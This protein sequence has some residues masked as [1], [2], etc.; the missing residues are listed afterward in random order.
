MRRLS[1]LDSDLEAFGR[2]PAHGSSFPA[3][4]AKPVPLAVVSLDSRRD[5]GNLVN[6]FMRIGFPLSVP[7]RVDCS[8]PEEGPRKSRSKSVPDRHAVARSRRGSSSSDPP[9]AD[10]FGTRTPCPPSS[11]SFS[12]SY[13]SILPTS[14]AYILPSTGGCSPWRPDAVMSTTGRER[15]SVLRIFKGRRGAPDTTNV[16]CSSSRWTLP[17]AESRFRG[18][19]A[20]KRKDNSSRGPRRRLGLPNVAVN[21]RVPFGNFNPIPFRSSRETRFRRGYPDS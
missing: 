20:V 5:S 6:P 15:Y 3:D 2:N 10:G 7:I 16:R 12:R 9:A 8:T 19:R 17:P 1:S 18:G 21:R 14:L 13:G 11:Q 4:Y